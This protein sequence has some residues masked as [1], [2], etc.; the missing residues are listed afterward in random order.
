M[1]NQPDFITLQITTSDRVSAD[2]E[3]LAGEIGAKKVFNAISRDVLPS[4]ERALDQRLKLE[5][6]PPNRPLRWKSRRQ[7]RFVM[8]LLKQQAIERGTYPDDISYWRT[9][10][11]S[12][13]WHAETQLDGAT[14][15]IL[16]ENNAQAPIKTYE[17]Y[18]TGGQYYA[19][20]VYGPHQQPFLTKW[21]LAENVIQ[22]TGELIE[23]R[24]YDLYEDLIA[25]AFDPRKKRR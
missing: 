18:T 8:W 3:N 10:R 19:E 2:L 5:P 1:A 14:V 24:L 13:S 17:G 15:H 7:Q 16:I 22:E 23:A 25:E 21:P 6:G 20:F 9:G 12:S 11:L 4:I